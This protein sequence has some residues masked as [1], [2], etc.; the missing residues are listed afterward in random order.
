MIV[1]YYFSLSLFLVCFLEDSY[2]I[3]F[4]HGGLQSRSRWWDERWL[5][6]FD[7]GGN[8]FQRYTWLSIFKKKKKSFCIW[9]TCVSSF[10]MPYRIKIYSLLEDGG[11]WSISVSRAAQERIVESQRHQFELWDVHVCLLVFFLGQ[12]IT[13]DLLWL[14]VIFGWR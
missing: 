10:S 1:F 2:A 11:L 7:E 6:I 3:A 8:L 4:K 5:L 9:S 12:L 14:S 13:E